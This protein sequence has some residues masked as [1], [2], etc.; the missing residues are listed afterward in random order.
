LNQALVN[1]RPLKIKLMMMNMFA[2]GKSTR[3]L[4]G[5]SDKG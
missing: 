4:A 3:G 5:S 2:Q 1:I